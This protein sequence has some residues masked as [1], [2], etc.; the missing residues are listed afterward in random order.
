MVDG[1]RQQLSKLL[2]VENLQAAAAGDL[3]HSRGMEAMVVVT[4]TTLDEDT[5]ITQTFCIH[6]PANIVQMDTWEEAEQSVT[7]KVEATFNSKHKG[8]KTSVWSS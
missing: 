2:V 4:V 3:T 1:L 7:S 5:A 6:F 8:P